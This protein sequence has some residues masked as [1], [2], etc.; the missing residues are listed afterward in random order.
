[1][2]GYAIPLP[3]RVRLAYRNQ[4][5]ARIPRCGRKLYEIL[6]FICSGGY[7]V[8]LWMV[9]QQISEKLKLIVTVKLE[10]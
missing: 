9:I 6:P 2:I 7:G 8:Y 1:M 10:S 4:H 3:D 5:T